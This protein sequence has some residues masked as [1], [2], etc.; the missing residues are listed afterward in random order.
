MGRI[1]T[2][3]LDTAAGK[4]AA[5][6]Q[7]VL[8]PARRTPAVVAEARDQCGRPGRPA[9]AGR[10]GFAAGRYEIVFHVG[11]YFRRAGV[12]LPDPPFLDRRAAA[13]RRRGGRALSRAAA[14]LALCLLDLSGQ[15]MRHEVRFLRRGKVV[16]LQRFRPDADPARLPA[17]DRARDRHQGRLRRRRLRRLHGG[18]AAPARRAPGL[19]A[20]QCLHPARRAGRRHRGHHGRRSRARTTNCI[21]CSR[22]WSTIT[23]RNA[24]SARRAS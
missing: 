13:L 18:A 21:R 9:A 20:G 2:H 16:T 24:A 17:P 19:R 23:A 8:T 3:V 12:A 15:L 22:R 10:R 4:P 14:G 11:D 6:L 5:G 1:T 7:V